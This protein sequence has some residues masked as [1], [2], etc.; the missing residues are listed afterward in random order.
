VTGSVMEL[1]AGN[2]YQAVFINRAF[3]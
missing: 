2:A 3:T 1:V